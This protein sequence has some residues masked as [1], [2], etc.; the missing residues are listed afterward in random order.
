MEKA[1]S[2][3][4]EML[5]QRGY[6]IVEHEDNKIIANKNDGEPFA[7]FFCESKKFNVEKLK[8]FMSYMNQINI[9]HSIIVYSGIITSYVNKIIE[10]CN[11]IKIELFAEED[12]QYNITKHRLQP[13]FEKIPDNEAE[14]FKKKW[15]KFPVMK[16][17]DPISK[18]YNY[19]RGD[20]IKITR[21]DGFVTYRIVR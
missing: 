3:C 13:I 16:Y 12:L 5:V 17:E 1:Y 18:F 2:I 15:G 6:I 14:E 9:K 7:A 8:E 19:S 11:D 4:S 10:T 21:K 20:V